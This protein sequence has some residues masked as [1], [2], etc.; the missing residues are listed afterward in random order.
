MISRILDLHNFQCSIS[1]SQGLPATSPY[2]DVFCFL[3]ASSRRLFRPL[4]RSR[5][6]KG[7]K[8]DP[9]NKDGQN[10]LLS[11]GSC[12]AKTD[13]TEIALDGSD[14]KLKANIGLQ[15]NGTLHCKLWF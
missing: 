6:R 3:P 12:K 11:Q 1:I 2:T 7:K 10:S 4:S 14:C 9:G 8:R 15:K 13:K 5:D